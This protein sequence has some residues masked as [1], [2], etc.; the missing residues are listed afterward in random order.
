[1]ETGLPEVIGAVDG[2][3]IRISRL[4]ESEDSY[5]NRKK[6]H[7]II[8]LGVCNAK[9]AFAQVFIGFP[10]RVHD[11]RVFEESCLFR[12]QARVN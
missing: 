12:D 7:C 6:F 11:A 1:M 10:G 4:S 9:R 3:E 8:L 5:C 2:C